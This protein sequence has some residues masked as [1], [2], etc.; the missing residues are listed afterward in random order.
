MGTERIVFTP[1]ERGVLD[2]MLSEKIQE[3]AQKRG[4]SAGGEKIGQRQP[5][6]GMQK[7]E[8]VF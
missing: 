2:N 8:F 1:A 6:D 7:C 3:I 5:E 4:V